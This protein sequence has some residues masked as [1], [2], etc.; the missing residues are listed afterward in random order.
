MGDSEASER[1]SMLS[2]V[3]QCSFEKHGRL[4]YHELKVGKTVVI[5]GL[6]SFSGKKLNDRR[7]SVIKY[8]S[9]VARFDVDVVSTLA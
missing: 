6:T 4:P 8:H 1:L 2:S 7:G 9:Q 3:Q 5:Y